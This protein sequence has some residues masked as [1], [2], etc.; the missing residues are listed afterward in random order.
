MYVELIPEG[1]KFYKV[2]MHNHTTLS[3]GTQTPEEIKKQYM[4]LGY[5]AVA[6]TDHEILFGHKELCD[7]NFVALHGYE[8]AIKKD[9]YHHTA[10]F[11]PVYHFNMIAKS[12]D[13]LTMVRFFKNNPSFPGKDQA[14][15]EAHAKYSSTID[16]YEYNFDWINDYTKAI[17]EAGFLVNYN[18]PQWS[19]QDLRDFIG[20]EN[21]HSVEVI[22]GGCAIRHNDNTSIHYEQMLRSGM[23]VVPTA[24]DDNHHA[25]DCATAWTMIKAPEL[26]YDALIAAYERGDCYVSEGP[27]I[28]S[29]V[30]T[31]GKIK[32]KTSAASDIILLSEGRYV[33][34]FRASD[35]PLTEAEFS[36]RPELFGRYFRIEV[37]DPKGYKA[38]SNAYYT[39]DIAKK[40]NE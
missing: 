1:G 33:Q 12:Q 9:M 39:E 7:E 5:S 18:H 14:F 24:G 35:E 40:T 27:E 20:L 26:T 29:L 11:Q 32:I 4:A 23:Q 31:D 21:L 25:C 8:V 10:F 13:N 38:F 19:L 3:D 34:N 36:Y 37:R 28:L 30:L 15:V 6:F 22:N 17:K 16:T 2:N